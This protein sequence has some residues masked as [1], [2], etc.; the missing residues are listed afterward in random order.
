MFQ[1]PTFAH[2]YSVTG[3][4]PAG[5]PHSDISGSMVICTY[6]KLFAAYHV[7]HRLREPRHPPSALLLLFLFVHTNYISIINHTTNSTTNKNTNQLNWFFFSFSTLFASSCLPY[8]K[9]IT[10][11]INYIYKYIY[12]S[13]I[14][15]SLLCCFVH[16]VKELVSL[17][18]NWK[19]KVENEIQTLFLAINNFC[20]STNA[21]QLNPSGE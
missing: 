16:H 10:I 8:N 4:Q 20:F 17:I 2:Y 5:L 3:L 12:I 18:E 19:L 15:K 1:F 9:Y 14:I 7:L 21:A 13:T 11:S 6:P